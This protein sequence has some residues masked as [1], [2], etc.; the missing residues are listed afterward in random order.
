MDRRPNSATYNNHISN[1]TAPIPISQSHAMSYR[2]SES[3][4]QIHVPRSHPSQGQQFHPSMHLES[5][6]GY[7]FD[8]KAASPGPPYYPRQSVPPPISDRQMYP[9]S[10]PQTYQ[11]P[12]D[13]SHAQYL[14]AP[15][16]YV[17]HR[18]SEEMS[19]PASPPRPFSCDMCALSFNRQH[20]L[21]R[22]RETHS[23][24]KP[25][26]CEACGKSFTRKDALKRH[27][28]SYSTSVSDR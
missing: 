5:F 3:F 22:H 4:A 23:G 7:N 20:D 17:A 18:Q 9:Q 24:D 15:P 11:P 1:C 27:Q 10:A 8:P 16:H 21:K 14:Q 19:Y 2:T 6:N 13:P 26:P 28:V 12:M 25:F